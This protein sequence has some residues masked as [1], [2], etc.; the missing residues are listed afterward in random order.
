MVAGE[1][2]RP[3]ASSNGGT[4]DM[5]PSSESWTSNPTSST[6]HALSQ[7]TQATVARDRW[8]SPKAAFCLTAVE[9]LVLTT[10]SQGVGALWRRYLHRLGVSPA[11]LA[12]LQTP[13]RLA[14]LPCH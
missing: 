5:A 2:R 12:S 3:A 4:E 11:P 14:S 13:T 10:G 9:L 1:R 7:P 6:A 8:C